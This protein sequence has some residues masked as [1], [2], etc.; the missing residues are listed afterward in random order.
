MITAENLNNG[1]QE[2]DLGFKIGLLKQSRQMKSNKKER[3]R[4]RQ[5]KRERK[6]F[7][8]KRK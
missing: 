7:I 2:E 1:E 5:R 4:E 6:L 3:K 8:H